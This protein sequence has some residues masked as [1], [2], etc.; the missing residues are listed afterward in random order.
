[1]TTPLSGIVDMLFHVV[2]AHPLISLVVFLVFFGS[3][4]WVSYIYAG[5]G[6]RRK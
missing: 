3:P 5:R 6:R 4:W 1:V 2:A